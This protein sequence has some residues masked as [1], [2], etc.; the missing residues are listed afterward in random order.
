MGQLFLCFGSDG[1]SV[2]DAVDIFGFQFHVL[3][4]PV[5]GLEFYAYAQF[6]ANRGGKVNVKPNQ[7]AVFIA[8][9]HWRESVVQADYQFTLVFYIRPGCVFRSIAA[10]AA[11]SRSRSGQTR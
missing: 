11:A 10:V 8:E 9:S 1:H 3:G 7:I 5:D 4:I 6:F 2:P